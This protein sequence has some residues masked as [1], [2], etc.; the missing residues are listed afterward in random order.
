MRKMTVA[1]SALLIVTPA[2][3][4]QG[5]DPAT[6]QRL[7]DALATQRNNALN[8]QAIAEAMLAVAKEDL[9]KAQAKIKDTEPKPDAPAK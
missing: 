2:L 3:A 5:L 1:L 9:V 7:M 4:Q 8:A 6:S